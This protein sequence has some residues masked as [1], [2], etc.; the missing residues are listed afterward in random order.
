MTLRR[1]SGALAGLSVLA[2]ASLAHAAEPR[3]VPKLVVVISVDQFSANLFSQ[4]RSR[5]VGGLRTLADQGLVYINGYQTHSGTET[6]PGHSTILT[7]A[8]P[9]RTGI[10]ANS[11][12]DRADA[13]IVYCVSV[14]EAA[15]PD[16]RGS[17]K[18]RVDTL[19]D[20]LKAARPGARSVAVSG[21]DR[22]AI[23]M[24]GHHPDAVYFGTGQ[25]NREAEE[26]I[27]EVLGE[28]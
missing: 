9:A 2:A 28:L 6:C 23:M 18:L 1:W 7:G 10:V 17:A 5:Y 21:K 20:W 8:H 25:R 14:A 4:Y 3:P 13:S 24:A 22:A 19:G 27:R 15:D 16:A 12:Y 26:A 11:W